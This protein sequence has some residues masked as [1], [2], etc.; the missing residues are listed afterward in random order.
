MTSLY[1]RHRGSTSAPGLAL[2]PKI[3]FVNVHLTSFSKMHMD[4]AAQ[5]YNVC[6]EGVV[7][8]QLMHI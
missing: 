7:G 2:L 5:I 6:M 3:K 4:F 8:T 1:E